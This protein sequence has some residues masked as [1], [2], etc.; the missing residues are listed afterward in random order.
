MTK[1]EYMR[2]IRT[3]LKRL[4]KQDLE[5]AL[6]YFDEYFQEA[7]PEQEASAMEDLGDPKAAAEQILRNLAINNAAEPSKKSIKRSMDSVWIGL[8]AICA[9]P[10]AL[11]LALVFVVVILV[12]LFSAFIFIGSF[13]VFGVVSAVASV[14]PLLAGCY[15]L[16]SNPASGIMTLGI[17]LLFLGGGL[18]VTLVCFT[19]ERLFLYGI[20]KLIGLCVK[21][22]KRH[23]KN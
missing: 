17:G 18:L 15:L 6:A 10:I 2:Q 8:L 1:A 16:V 12:L 11:P 14:I 20:V 21:G 5:Q 13:L 22:G 9:A 4:P 23:E 7:G 19:L 3:C